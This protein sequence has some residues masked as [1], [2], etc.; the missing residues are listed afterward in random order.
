MKTRYSIDF[1]TRIH[2]RAKLGRVSLRSPGNGA[3]PSIERK[4]IYVARVAGVTSE[5]NK[6]TQDLMPGRPNAI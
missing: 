4:R 3:R 5:D 1:R 6:F 2:Q